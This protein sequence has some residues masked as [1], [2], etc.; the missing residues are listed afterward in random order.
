[1][2]RVT[3]IESQVKDL[4]PEELVAV[5]EWFARFDAEAWDWEF[6]ADAKGGK[7]DS[8]AERA[9]DHDAG[10]SADL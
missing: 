8:L 9:F 6:K 10:R 2:S 3:S 5:R 1:M 4:S 7:L